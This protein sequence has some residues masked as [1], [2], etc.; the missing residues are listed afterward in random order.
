[1]PYSIMHSITDVA[2]KLN[3]FFI[4]KYKFD[5]IFLHLTQE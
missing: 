1:M 4:V 2:T 3:F 5:E